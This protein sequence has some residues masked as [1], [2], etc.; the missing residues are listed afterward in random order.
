MQYDVF[1]V[2]SG[3][4]R[5]IAE[6]LHQLLSRRCKVYLDSKN[7]QV[8]DVWH[9]ELPKALEN[10]EMLVVLVSRNAEN[11]YYVGEEIVQG[12]SSF[13]AKGRRV[14]PIFVGGEP[15]KDIEIPYGLRSLHYLVSRNET[16]LPDIAKEIL[17]IV[18][19]KTQRESEERFRIRIISTEP[20]L[21]EIRATVAD[22]LKSVYGV[23]VDASPV[24]LAVTGLKVD[25]LVLLQGLW[26]GGGAVARAW[27]TIPCSRHLALAVEE[28]GA[29][30]PAALFEFRFYDEISAF[31]KKF[32]NAQSFR[33]PSQLAE[34]V[35]KAVNQAIIER[36]KVNGDSQ[37][38]LS[39]SERAYLEFRLPGWRSGK[40][41]GRRTSRYRRIGFPRDLPIRA[42]CFPLRQVRLLGARSQRRHRSKD[43]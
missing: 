34:L 3:A 29:W 32:S 36:Q 1:I 14:A 23:D 16:D 26:W 33:E 11:A 8:G 12:I 5:E 28:G 40:S 9:K 10:S 30:P 19:P 17:K 7:L 18:K 41:V 20:D 22:Y 6:D 42:I 25:L 27:E 24:D 21:A 35:G 38:G 15:G 2:H 43:T 4:D 37:G 31:K 39:P 13:R